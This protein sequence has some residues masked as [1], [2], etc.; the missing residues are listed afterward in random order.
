MAIGTSGPALR[1]PN[2][3]AL[4]DLERV[5]TWAETD[6]ALNRATNG[7]LAADTGPEHRIAVFA[8]NSTEVVLVHSAAMRA[9]VSSTPINAMLTV[10]EATYILQDSNAA[11]LFCGPETVDVATEAARRAGITQVVA[12]RCSPSTAV[13]GWAAWLASGSPAEPPT[14][15]EPRRHLLYTSG[16][17]GRPKGTDL[18][19]RGDAST[20]AE[21][22]AALVGG[23]PGPSG[24]GPHL[25]VGPLHH[26]G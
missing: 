11:I 18:P 24:G 4:T 17:T 16:T 2:G 3:I 7:L 15:T 10:E 1:E 19:F 6:D 8:R 14:G 21:Y 13:D 25:V 12:W 22:L 9:G 5:L 20:V 26:T 23:L